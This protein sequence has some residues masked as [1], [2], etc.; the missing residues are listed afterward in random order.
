MSRL[1]EILEQ[2][3]D[4]T[5]ADRVDANHNRV[6]NE[7]DFVLEFRS[8]QEFVDM[9]N[10]YFARQSQYFVQPGH[11]QSGVD[12]LTEIYSNQD[13]WSRYV[14]DRDIYLQQALSDVKQ[15][16]T[17][18]IL[19]KLT[20]SIIEYSQHLYRE[21][22]LSDVGINELKELAAVAPE[23]NIDPA[24]TDNIKWKLLIYSDFRNSISSIMERH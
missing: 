24:H 21:Q 9:I 16:R 3:S 23:L 13:K 22:V 6:F 2:L 1:D 17:Y 14:E 4:Q 12:M 11:I 20:N 18:D 10:S 15:G 19:R 5:I 8:E 7:F